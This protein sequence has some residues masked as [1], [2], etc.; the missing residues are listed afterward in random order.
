M[1]GLLT[2]K[3]AGESHPDGPD[4][5][6]HVQGQ[7]FGHDHCSAE[8]ARVVRQMARPIENMIGCHQKQQKVEF[9]VQK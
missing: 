3:E 6:W 5:K 2:T 4:G 1:A 8:F 9:E 7:R